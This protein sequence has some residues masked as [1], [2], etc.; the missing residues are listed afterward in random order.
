MSTQLLIDSHF[1][2]YRAFHT[3]GQLTHEGE[4]TGVAFGFLREL[5]ILRE[6]YNPDTVVFAFD[7][8]GTGIRGEIYPDYKLKRRNRI[9]TEEQKIQYASFR[10]QIKK[11]KS[12]ILP[13]LGYNNIFSQ[14]GYEGDD[15]IAHFAEKLLGKDDAII[16]TADNDLWQCLKDNVI[17]YNPSSKKV[18]TSKSFQDKWKIDPVLWAGV[19]AI[20]GCSTDGVVGLKAIG[21]VIAARWFSG[22]LKHDSKAYQK[23]SNNIQI[24]NRNI[25]LTRLPLPG[26]DLPE[27]VSD[28]VTEKKGIKIEIELGIRTKRQARKK[29]EYTGFDI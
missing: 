11:L 10:E 17:W 8:G 20:S 5:H 21:E 6:M 12:K 15:I 27:L 14:K 2:C 29:P 9:F 25:K 22:D 28:E 23:I 16:V 3:T 24:H 1:L 26:L 7:F 4:A 18:I 19:K 13:A